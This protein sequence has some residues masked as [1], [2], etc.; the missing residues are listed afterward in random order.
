LSSQ[1]RND[2]NGNVASKFAIASLR[3]TYA[4]SAGLVA[5]ISG[6][7][8]CK[9]AIDCYHAAQWSIEGRSYK[10]VG[11]Y[12]KRRRNADITISTVAMRLIQGNGDTILGGV[13]SI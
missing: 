10:T 2:I 7:Q 1:A 12:L 9:A 11:T 3:Y 13:Q 6:G 4:E 5:T 8:G